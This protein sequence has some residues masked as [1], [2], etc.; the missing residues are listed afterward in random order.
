MHLSTSIFATLFAV[1]ER[2]RKKDNPVFYAFP[3]LPLYMCLLTLLVVLFSSA[4]SPKCVYTLRIPE[5]TRL[6]KFASE[7]FLQSTRQRTVFDT[8]TVCCLDLS[9]CV[10][11]PFPIFRLIPTYEVLVYIMIVFFVTI[12]L[13]AEPHTQEAL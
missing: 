6:T 7:P 9:M 1:K 13:Y 3:S 12:P 10:A 11:G 8:H 4:W 2:E 5:R